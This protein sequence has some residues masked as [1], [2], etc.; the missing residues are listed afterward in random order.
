MCTFLWERVIRFPKR[1]LTSKKFY[2][3][4]HWEVS[5]GRGAEWGPEAGVHGLYLLKPGVDLGHQIRMVPKVCAW[6][7]S[8]Q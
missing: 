5:R 1:P 7:C 8:T 3:P 6:F 2:R 4:L